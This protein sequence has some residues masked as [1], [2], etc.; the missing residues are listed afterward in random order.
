MAG[1]EKRGARIRAAMKPESHAASAKKR[2]EALLARSRAKRG[3]R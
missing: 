3:R 1:Q 2:E